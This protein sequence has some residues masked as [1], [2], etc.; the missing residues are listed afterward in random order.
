MKISFISRFVV[1]AVFLLLCAAWVAGYGTHDQFIQPGIKSGDLKSI[2][3]N[4]IVASSV[5]PP[6]KPG[7]Y[8]GTLTDV[9]LGD[10]KTFNIWVASE[11]SSFGVAGPL[12]DTLIGQNSYTLKW[13]GHLSELPTISK[14]GLVW[15][16]RLKPGLK[17]SDGQPITADDVIFT[18]KMI[19]DPKTQGIMRESMLVDVVDHR[20]KKSARVPL[21]Y[22]KVDERTVEFRFPVP[23]APARSMLAI[24]VAPRHKL[25]AAWKSGQINS[26]WSVSTNPSELVASGTWIMQSYVPGQRVVYGRNPHY[27]KKDTLGRPLPY[28]DKY[29][30]LIVPD[31][32]TE[33]LKFKAGECDT[34]GVQ[35]TDYPSVKRGEK[36]G[37]YTVYDLGPSWGFN[38]LGFNLN[39]QAKVEPWKIKLFENV[40]FRQAVSYAINRD[41]MSVNLFRGLAEPLYSPLT[42]ANKIFFNPDVPKY[43]YNKQKAGELLDEINVRDNDGNGYRE[44]EGHEVQ[45]NIVTNVENNLRKSM[46]TVITKDLKNVGINAIFTPIN[47]NKLVAGLDSPPY[48]W[49]AC[50][51]GFTGGPEPHDGANIWFS[52]GP[53]H[54]WRPNQK[55]PA[56][57]WEAEIDN[58]FRKG[59]QT[60]DIKQR[61]AIYGRWQVIAAEQL[62]FIYTVVPDSIVAIRNKFGNLKPSPLGAMWNQEEIYDLSATRDAP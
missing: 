44:F 52:S 61:E 40:K 62:P 57:P 41:L 13:E 34:L 3:L 14:D 54:Q 33:T 35:A 2:G 37:N 49:E 24:A 42:P 18:V 6:S 12:Y 51:L 9:T 25:E 39:P 27:W 20:T 43:P 45:F 60:L 28:F 11:A 53:S 22:R 10:P 1:L 29:V 56:T 16:F 15:T 8:G 21:K 4:R 7:K 26:T 19:Y 30:Q 55:T 5:E 48:Q 38:Y 31:L 50:I 47:F 17:W 46:A 59:A 23:Y 32:N 58:L 36:A